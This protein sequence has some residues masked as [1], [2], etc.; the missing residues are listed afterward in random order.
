MT[1]V[2]PLKGR[3]MNMADYEFARFGL[4]VPA[5]TSLEDVLDDNYLRNYA[6]HL[7][8]GAE[9]I[10][11]SDD[12]VLDVSLRVMR[13]TK[14][15]VGCRVIRDSSM[16]PDAAKQGVEL[17]EGYE[18]TWGG[19]SHKHRVMLNGDLVEHGFASKAL[20]AQAAIKHNEARL[21]G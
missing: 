9:L 19:P 10:I 8:P 18:V 13:T 11:L 12:Y 17:P 2:T 3:R 5:E 14:T 1:Q 15:T 20:A 7:K 16:K 6:G 4:R 21:N